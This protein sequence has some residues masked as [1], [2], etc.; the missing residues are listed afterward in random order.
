MQ[1]VTV[2]VD[3]K[4]RRKLAV[5]DFVIEQRLSNQLNVIP[6]SGN[7]RRLRVFITHMKTGKRDEPDRAQDE[8]DGQGHSLGTDQ[9]YEQHD[10]NEGERDWVRITNNNKKTDAIAVQKKSEPIVN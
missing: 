5:V 4:G 7:W 9:C 8:A 1:S 6:T 10:R 2:G 3:S